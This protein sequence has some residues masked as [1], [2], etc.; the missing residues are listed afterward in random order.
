MDNNTI[1]FFQ[2]GKEAFEKKEYLKVYLILIY[3]L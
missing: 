3:R 2:Q 1:S